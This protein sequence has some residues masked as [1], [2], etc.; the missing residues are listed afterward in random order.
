MT[1]GGRGNECWNGHWRQDS[2]ENE[3]PVRGLPTNWVVAAGRVGCHVAGCYGNDPNLKA[4]NE[5]KGS[6][7]ECKCTSGTQ[8]EETERVQE[9]A[10]ANQAE[11]QAITTRP[12]N[13]SSTEEHN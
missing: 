11:E 4:G 13:G 10:S 9:R 7:S 6:H 1:R 3:A 8:S 2:K 5:S 12:Q